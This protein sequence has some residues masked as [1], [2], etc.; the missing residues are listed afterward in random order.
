MTRTPH[1]VLY[2]PLLFQP[3]PW[4][5]IM[6]HLRLLID[7]LDRTRFE[8]L[9]VIRDRD[10]EQ[11]G[12]LAERCQLPVVHLPD[13]AR[14]LDMRAVCRLHRVSIVH[15]HTP[16]T[17]GVPATAL[18][19]RLAGAK[20]VLT[21][22]QYQ[23]ERLPRRTRWIN[24]AVQRTLLSH[25]TA[26][27]RG[28]AE[29]HASN[30]GLVRERIEIVENGI[31]FDAGANQEAVLGPRVAGELRVAYFG[32]LAHEKGLLDLL[33]AFAKVHAAVPPARLY[34]AGAGY[35]DEELRLRAA[36]LGI[37]EAV[38]FLGYR[39]DARALMR[40]MDVIVHAPLYEGFGLSVI[41]AMA[42]GRAVVATAA[43]G[44]I[45][46]LI[47]DGVDG[48]LTPVAQPEALAQ[49]LV[50]VL[51]DDSLRAALGDHAVATARSRFD[52]AL[53]CE[54]IVSIYERLLSR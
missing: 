18:G 42:A 6:E 46:E 2:V 49:A 33:N 34:L 25:T 50:R 27:S 38:I 15:I 45:P 43:P 13:K 11:T 32:R 7:R 41:E 16:V 5:G 3:E 44:G 28:V 1:R 30:A 40:E 8:P 4:N 47:Q 36:A 21:L 51:R 48:L 22:H 54:R 24:R 14:P 20:V 52:A 12:R 10:G 17:S 23:P 39:A 35:L 19:A 29:A 37:A 31:D 26:V 9:L 53:M